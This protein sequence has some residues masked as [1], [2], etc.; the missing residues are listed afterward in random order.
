M[1]IKREVSDKIGFFS[2]E[3]NMYG[4]DT[5]FYMRMKEA[6]YEAFRTGGSFVHYESN[7][8]LSV[9]PGKKEFEKEHIDR[10]K[11]KWGLKEDVYFVRKRKNPGRFLERF[12]LKLFYG[13]NFVEKSRVKRFGKR[14]FG[15]KQ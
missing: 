5:D 13:H 2:E 11:K 1:L 7:A 4:E 8:A 3:F 15:N 14:S 9:M 12:Y 6:G 10:L